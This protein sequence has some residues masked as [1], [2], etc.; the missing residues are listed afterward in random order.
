MAFSSNIGR[1]PI[2]DDSNYIDVVRESDN[3]P[4]LGRGLI[5]RDYSAEPFG[6]LQ[7][8]SAFNIPTIPRAEWPRLIEHREQTKSQLTDYGVPIK[9]QARTN[10]CWIFCCAKA[11]EV[12]RAYQGQRHV[13]LSPASAGAKIKNYRNVGGWPGE[14]LE[15][16][17][18]HGIVPSSLWPDTAIERRYD[19]EASRNARAHFRCTEW[20]ELQPRRFDQLATCLLLGYPVAIGLSW[21]RHAVTA[22]DLVALDRGGFGV[23]IDNS[24]GANWGEAGRSVLTESKA[25][26]D[27]AITPRVVTASDWEQ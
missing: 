8:A 13:S 24:W 27:D 4:S 18:Q 19:N 16:I 6:T 17:A 22:M 20:F 1:M 25:T 3:T 14:G 11:I 23:V 10:Y 26:P 5:P 9:N 2:I 12:V 15:Y 21:W 7:Y